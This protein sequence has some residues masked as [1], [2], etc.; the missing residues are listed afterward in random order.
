MGGGTKNFGFFLK[1]GGFWGATQRR[2]GISY[3][4]YFLSLKFCFLLPVVMGFGVFSN[5]RSWGGQ[6]ILDASRRGGGEKFQT[7]L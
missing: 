1:G 7:H 5:F 6:E 4:N 2:G 3:L